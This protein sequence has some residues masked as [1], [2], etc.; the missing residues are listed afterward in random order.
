MS[1]LKQLPWRQLVPVTAFAGLLSGCDGSD[2]GIM[3][4]ATSTQASLA[5]A[6]HAYVASWGVLST[7]SIDPSTGDLTASG[8]SPLTFPVLWPF[9]GIQQIA[10]DPSGQFLYVLHFSGVY[11]YTID[12][13]TGALTKVAGSPF[14]AGVGP[15][16]FAFDASGTHLYVAAGTSVV[17][18]VNTLISAFSVQPSGALVPLKNYVLSGELSTVVTA[19]N[20]LYVAG[21]YTNSI[22]V[23]SIAPSGELLQTVPGSPFA[24]DTGP[25]SIATDPSGSVL[26][27]ANAGQPT[28]TQAAP[29]S[30]SAFAIDASTGA[31][32]PWSR[33]PLPVPVDAQISIDPAGRFLFVPATSGVSVYAID[34]ASAGLSEVAGSPFSAGTNPD[35]VS[36]DPINQI[37]YVVNAGSSNV[38]EFALGSAGTL[39]PL[40]GSPA[41]V[42]TSPSS[43]AISR[44]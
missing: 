25:F 20:H 18:P 19:C 6:A 10:T 44:Q 12:P 7:Y 22:T 15:Y 1:F 27:T 33:N 14:A 17:A 3:S 32:I 9:G 13:N 38:S 29:G 24:T 21:F 35:A 40:A 11:A 4:S 36:V 26:Y 16:S 39:T 42:V 5:P 23:F 2:T 43:I 30:I 34:A 37:A 28:A 8:S 31:L 41:P